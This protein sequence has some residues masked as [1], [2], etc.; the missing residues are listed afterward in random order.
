MP[1]IP[2]PTRCRTSTPANHPHACCWPSLTRAPI[3]VT[4][5]TTPVTAI[6]AYGMN[7]A[8]GAELLP[9]ELCPITKNAITARM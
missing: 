1:M 4:S 7:K 9:C 5:I 8:G 3:H 2:S 6:T